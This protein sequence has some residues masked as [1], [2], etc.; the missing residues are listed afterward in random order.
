MTT[1]LPSNLSLTVF[2]LSIIL[3]K[4]ELRSLHSIDVHKFISRLGHRKVAVSSIAEPLMEV[5]EL[6]ELVKHIVNVTNL[7]TSCFSNL[8]LQVFRYSNQTRFLIVVHS[9]AYLVLLFKYLYLLIFAPNHDFQRR[10]LFQA[11]L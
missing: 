10:L 11:M 6:L 8:L 9:R 5:F 1:H 2:L 7:Q 3:L 4:E